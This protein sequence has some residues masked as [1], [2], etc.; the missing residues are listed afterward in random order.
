MLRRSLVWS[1]EPKKWLWT[2]CLGEN[3]GGPYKLENFYSWL[4]AKSAGNF[5]I[6]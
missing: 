5:I 4:V 3:I 1:F 2:W 6:L